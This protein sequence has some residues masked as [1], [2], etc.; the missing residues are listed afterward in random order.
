MITVTKMNVNDILSILIKNPAIFEAIGSDHPK[1][2]ADWVSFKNNPNC[3]CRGRVAK[4]FVDLLD[5]EPNALDKHVAADEH[6]VSI[7]LGKLAVQRQANSYVG[8]TFK[9]QK[10]EEAWVNFSNE[11][12]TKMFRSFSVVEKEDHL[13]IYFIWYL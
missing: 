5:T 9:I 11:S 7:E 10:I 1:I 4:Y 6:T 2:I 12:S 8:K 3:T 13:V